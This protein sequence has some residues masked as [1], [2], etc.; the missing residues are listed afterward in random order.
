MLSS[1]FNSDLRVIRIITATA[2]TTILISW[3]VVPAKLSFDEY[4][5]FGT[6]T[7]NEL[8]LE[9]YTYEYKKKPVVF[10]GS[11]I[12]TML[13]PPNCRPDD[14]AAVYLQGRSAMSGLEAIRRVGAA[15]KVLFVEVTQLLIPADEH[16]LAA[17]FTPLYWRIRTL[18][19]PLRHNRNWIVLFHRWRV[20]ERYIDPD[21]WEL[22]EQTV[23]EWYKLRSVQF[24]VYQ[25]PQSNRGL[26]KAIV[27]D[28]AGRVRA[29]QQNGTRVIFYNSVDPSI[30]NNPPSSELAAEIKS[31]M[32]DVEYINAPDDEFP[33]YRWD[34]MHFV[35]ASGV[36]VFEY[37]MRRAGLPAS[38]KCQ[39]VSSVK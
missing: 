22:P 26:A 5:V 38:S 32:P 2:L 33:I 27:T 8:I 25:H 10:L 20:H 14:V 1:T 28:V 24:G 35:A 34:G 18:I 30:R 19:P 4:N 23:A 11:S 16:L 31:Q 15:P 13:P 3:V 12:L 6:Q 21:I 17:V 9:K 39:V 7:L 29:L 37:L 36:Q